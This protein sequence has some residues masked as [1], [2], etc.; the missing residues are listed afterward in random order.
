MDFG[1]LTQTGQAAQQDSV[2]PH[3]DSRL[4]AINQRIANSKVDVSTLCGYFMRPVTAMGEYWLATHL[5]DVQKEVA[6]GTLHLYF[7]KAGGGIQLPSQEL[8]DHIPL[9]TAFASYDAERKSGRKEDGIV[10]FDNDDRNVINL[11]HFL[12]LDQEKGT[13]VRKLPPDFESAMEHVLDN[14]KDTGEER[15]R[16]L[17]QQEYREHAVEYSRLLLRETYNANRF[18]YPRQN[19]TPQEEECRSIAEDLI[20]F[21]AEKMGLSLAAEAT[22]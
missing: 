12:H 11:H 15:L 4:D 22:D 8:E 18:R 10:L 14:I 6:A 16:K 17:T 20:R 7:S 2:I 9:P 5:E 21:Y 13:F 1:Q 19:L 3:T